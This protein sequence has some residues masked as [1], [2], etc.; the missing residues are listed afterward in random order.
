MKKSTLRHINKNALKTTAL[1]L[2]T[3][4]VIGY[5]THVHFQ[6]KMTKEEQIDNFKTKLIQYERKVATTEPTK[7]ETQDDY[8]AVEISGKMPRIAIIYHTDGNVSIMIN[9]EYLSL[10]AATEKYPVLTAGIKKHIEN[11][12]AKT[13]KTAETL[14]R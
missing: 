9:H 14:E 5:Q 12:Q 2:A 11:T 3:V 8:Q 7:V 6:N 13:I 10:E 4:G 1:L